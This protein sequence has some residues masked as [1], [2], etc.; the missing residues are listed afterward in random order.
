MVMERLRK[1][2]ER[3]ATRIGLLLSRVSSNP[4]V[5]TFLGLALAWTSPVLVYWRHLLAGAIMIPVSGLVDVFDGAV[6]RATKRASKRGE[7]LDSVLDRFSD[8]AYFY[9]LLGYGFQAEIVLVG[10][11]LALSISYV[12]AKGEVLG[13]EMRGVGLME[14]GDR[15]LAITLIALLAALG[16]WS[17]SRL[18]LWALVILMAYTVASRSWRVI[19]ALTG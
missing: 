19:K 16:L 18:L 4:D 13:V 15:I 1:R 6:A 7:F 10:L 5:Y 12:R 3:Q 2:V 17:I 11:S 14:R 9:A 8:T